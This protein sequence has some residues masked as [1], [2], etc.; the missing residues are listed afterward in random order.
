MGK[1]NP[2]APVFALTAEHPGPVRENAR[3][4]LN[5]NTGW[6]YIFSDISEA[7]NTGYDDSGAAGITLPHYR[8]KYDQYTIDRDAFERMQTVNWYRRHFSLPE[9]CAGGRVS[10]EFNGGGQ[11]N[12]IY[13]NGDYVGEARGHFTHFTFD[14]TDYIAF[15]PYDNVIAVQVNSNVY[16][17]FMPPSN[18]SGFHMFGGLHGE[19]RMVITDRACI[20]SVFYYNDTVSAGD[21]TASLNGRVFIKNTYDLEQA[22]IVESV[23]TDKT[24]RVVSAAQKSETLSSGEEKATELAHTVADPRLW[25]LND[26]YL[27]TVRT[28]LRTAGY[29]LDQTETDIGI[30]SF[31]VTPASRPGG[32]FFLNGEIIEIIGV[33][34]HMQWPYIGNALTPKLNAKDAH[35]I[36]YDLGLN[37]VR[38]SHY[39]NDP[40]FLTE[41]D[42][43]GL[44]VE[45]EALACGTT[46]DWY[47]Q[48]TYS[49]YEMV[50]RDR[51]HASIVMWSILSNER[52]ADYPSVKESKRMNRAV[53]ALDPSRLTIQEEHKDSEIATDVYGWHDYHRPND[54]FKIPVKTGSWIVSEWNNDCGRNF[55][56]PGDSELRKL[57]QL[58]NYTRNLERYYTHPDVLGSLFFAFSGYLDQAKERGGDGRNSEFGR[59]FSNWRCIG[60]VGPQRDNLNKY[61]AGYMFQSQNMFAD[62]ADVLHICCEWKSDSLT[63]SSADASIT[64][65]AGGYAY[66]DPLPPANAVYVVSNFDR[67]D[68]WYEDGGTEKLIQSL[69]GPNRNT[70][71][72]RGLFE[73]TLDPA[74][75]IWTPES[76]LTA[77]G[78]RGG[79]HVKSYTR[80]A[81]AIE[82]EAAGID[83]VHIKLHDTVSGAVG[84]IVADG[85]DMAWIIAE[86]LDKNNQRVYYADETVTVEKVSGDGEVFFGGKAMQM[87]D[88]L[89]GFYI[90]SELDKPGEVT[91]R[92]NVTFGKSF[93]DR[94]PCF[95]YI[96]DWK[97][98]GPDSGCDIIQPV[99][100]AYRGS[101]H[102]SDKAGSTATVSFTGTQIA[103]YGE[104]V[105]SHRTANRQIL[106][107]DAA[108]CVDGGEEKFVLFKNQDRY[109]TISNCRMYLSPELP[110]GE[111]TLT[112]RVLTDGEPVKLDRVKVFDNRTAHI[113]E[114]ITVCIKPWDGKRVPL[115]AGE[116]V[117]APDVPEKL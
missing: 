34:K 77:K 10:V 61:W 66:P 9:S 7:K 86:I 87:K 58:L 90:K 108:V 88:G 27:Y 114:T 26:P 95:T 107:Y 29:V 64:D 52:S 71:L 13:V 68:L 50:K 110:Y 69:N 74:E 103:L 80:Y 49:V 48:Y 55:I 76:K 51:N 6:K 46:G 70:G 43:I 17:D 56:M 21:K 40:A 65:P 24:G 92:V 100:D 22:L 73:F 20:D 1:L 96:G 11:I 79:A 25:N 36:K 44:L 112:L 47:G 85:T 109:G 31:T 54:S 53:K 78:Y 5:F 98:C 115:P 105:P 45:E 23:V 84:P 117:P 83:G 30:R 94:D 62:A 63:L 67:V 41:C 104:T 97:T 101:Y 18:Q 75:H 37:M 81:S 15:G 99:Y 89:A 59:V 72:P 4:A 33:N 93:D 57:K 32:H 111:H 82:P 16:K 8:E 60:T 2:S 91:A 102:I 106:P 113:S 14:I 3:K 35:T 42:K 19:A 39:A 116:A 12:R 28:T 38:T